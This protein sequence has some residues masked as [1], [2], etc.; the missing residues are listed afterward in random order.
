MASL[1]TSE[2]G[3]TNYMFS[4]NN[5][6]GS[7]RTLGLKYCMLRLFFRNVRDFIEICHTNPHSNYLPYLIFV[8][9]KDI[10]HIDERASFL[11]HVCRLDYQL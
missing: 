4:K 6:S 5:K 11:C 2:S 7:R 8:C 3:S 10:K 9:T 1:E